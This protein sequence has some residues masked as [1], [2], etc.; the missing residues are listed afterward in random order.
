MKISSPS[1]AEGQPIPAKDAYKQGNVSPELKI[2]NIPAETK[3]LILIVDDPDGP[4]GIW[5]HWLVWGISPQAGT[6]GEG[7]APA[8]A[9]VG[10]NDFGENKYDGPAPPK[11]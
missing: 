6:I 11:G 3:S 1:F 2:E 7:Q 4:V 10:N 8:G 9:T 5:S